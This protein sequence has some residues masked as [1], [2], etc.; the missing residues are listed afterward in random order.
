MMSRA[1]PRTAAWATDARR[2]A[3]RP[4]LGHHAH[5]VSAARH[6]A[7]RAACRPPWND[8]GTQRR[9]P[10][11]TNDK[12]RSAKAAHNSTNG[13]QRGSAATRGAEL[14]RRRSRVRVPSLP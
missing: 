14:S 9:Q 1:L 4:L 5:M 8:C 11:A 10:M 7:R 2:A 13:D 6:K 3:N 12:S